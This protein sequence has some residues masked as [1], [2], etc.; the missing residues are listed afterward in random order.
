MQHSHTYKCC[1]RQDKNGCRLG[2]TRTD[3]ENSAWTG[4]CLSEK[5][6][7]EAF[8][9][10]DPRAMFSPHKSKTDGNNL[11]GCFIYFDTSWTAEKEAIRGN[12]LRGKIDDEQ[13]LK[14][15][16]K[17]DRNGTI[18]FQRELTLCTCHFNDEQVV[19]G[20]RGAWRLT[21][22]A[23]ILSPTALVNL[24][25]RKTT[26]N[27]HTSIPQQRTMTPKESHLQQ[28]MDY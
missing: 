6:S 27:P 21:A 14:Y 7:R 25:Q 8:Y 23:T 12:L 19:A 26:S 5:R 16:E 17:I 3:F 20:Q 1:C 28:Q 22:D 24:R 10:F 13:F 11:E 4:Q 18:E 2:Y 9:N 15:M